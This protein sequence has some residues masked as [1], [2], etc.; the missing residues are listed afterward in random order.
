MY[1]LQLPATLKLAN[2]KFRAA[3]DAAIDRR[4]RM[5]QKGTRMTNRNRTTILTRRLACM[6]VATLFSLLFGAN[7][8]FANFARV[9]ALTLNSGEH[10]P[11]CTVIDPVGGFAYFGL[12]TSPGTVVKV[13]LS[14]FTRVGALTLNAG[15]TF[16]HSAVIDPAGGFADFATQTSPRVVVQ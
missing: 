3:G 14:D 15:E 13:R 2:S 8:A 1:R 11:Q 12:Q 9:G 6:L 7:S 4:R 10:N 5:M 16:L